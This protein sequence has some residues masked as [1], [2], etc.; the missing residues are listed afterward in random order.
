M[1]DARTDGTGHAREVWR[2]R[3]VGALAE[4]GGELDE[5]R[6]L[7][8]GACQDNYV[9]RCRDGRRWV[10]RSDAPS[11]LPGSLD[12]AM[13]AQVVRAAV[14]NGVPTPAV[15]AVLPDLF[16]EGATAVVMDW[17]D[18]VAIGAKVVRRTEV[19]PVLTV[20][21]A[22]ALARIHAVRPDMAPDVKPDNPQDASEIDAVSAALRFCRVMLDGIP[23]RPAAERIYRWLD[24]NRPDP[25]PVVLAHGDYRVGNFLV[26]DDG[27]EAVLDWE[28]AHWGSAG[29]DLAWLTVRDWRFGRLDHAVGGIAT[30]RD[31]LA[32]YREAGGVVLPAEALRWWEVLGNLRWA[33]GAL[34]QTVRVLSGAQAD[35]ELL[36]IGRRAA[37]MEWE[38]LRRIGVLQGG[39]HA[40]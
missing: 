34:F 30:R 15:R 5:L 6:P 21:L 7:H 19:H 29:E 28:F 37:E 9:A 36:A 4:L 16:R 35:L 24:A 12:R 13:E 11:S 8:G 14:A 2:P 23:L 38:A 10:V 1:T 40:G 3:L 39:A 27:L 25:G 26:G 33:T 31:F 20:Q 17:A 32:A 18:G 22:R